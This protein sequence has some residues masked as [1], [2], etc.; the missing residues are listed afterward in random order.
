MRLQPFCHEKN[1]WGQA[2]L[3][4]AAAP[5][6]THYNPKL[7]SQCF[8]KPPFPHMSIGRVGL[9]SLR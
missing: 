7:G 9:N 8:P 6:L 2:I 1:Y 4:P 3:A 5:Q